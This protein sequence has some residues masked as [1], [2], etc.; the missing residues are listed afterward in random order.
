MFSEATKSTIANNR[1]IRRPQWITRRRG[2]PM[3]LRVA[4]F[5]SLTKPFRIATECQAMGMNTDIGPATQVL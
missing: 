1:A 2:K 3:I 4:I 5:I